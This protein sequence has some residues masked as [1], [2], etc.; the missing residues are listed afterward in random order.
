MLCLQEQGVSTNTVLNFFHKE[1]LSPFLHLPIHSIIYLI[2]I[3]YTIHIL[4]FGLK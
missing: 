3:I 4:L 2:N 1:I